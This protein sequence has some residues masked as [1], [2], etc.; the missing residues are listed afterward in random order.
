MLD[1]MLVFRQRI[2][3]LK[4][5]ITL[6][7]LLAMGNIFASPEKLC[8]REQVNVYTGELPLQCESAHLRSLF[9]KAPD[10]L[11]KLQKINQ[12]ASVSHPKVWTE[13]W[14]FPR[15]EVVNVLN[16]QQTLLSFPSAGYGR[17]LACNPFELG[18]LGVPGFTSLTHQKN[19]CQQGIFS[20]T[21]K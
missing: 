9:Y 15:G 5:V 10:H 6:M 12:F 19:I 17:Y 8:A 18:Y 16:N 4:A 11:L 14:L 7:L 1:V 21:A 13:P 3:Q 2:V 20:L